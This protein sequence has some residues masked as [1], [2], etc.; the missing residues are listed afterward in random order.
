MR[1]EVGSCRGKVMREGTKRK[2]WREG[3]NV[4]T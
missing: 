4:P 2:E 1:G 3:G